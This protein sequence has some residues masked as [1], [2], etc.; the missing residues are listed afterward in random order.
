MAASESAPLGKGLLCTEV[1][2]HT[3]ELVPL[4]WAGICKLLP[5]KGQV[6]DR[7]RSK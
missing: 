3:R 2:P 7:P 6:S 1:H 4:K 5:L